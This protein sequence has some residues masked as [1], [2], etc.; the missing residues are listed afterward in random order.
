MELS[1]LKYIISDVLNIDSE[2]IT[3]DTNFVDDLGADSLDLFQIITAIETEAGIEFD[4]ENADKIK[5]V[6]DAMNE[7]KRLSN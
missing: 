7:I 4:I 3:L 5:T 2:E 6:S 1:K